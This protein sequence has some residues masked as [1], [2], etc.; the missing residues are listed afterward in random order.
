MLL[1]IASIK[2]EKRNS[3]NDLFLFSFYSC[4]SLCRQVVSGLDEMEAV[5]DLDEGTYP[6]KV[7]GDSD[8]NSAIVSTSSISHGEY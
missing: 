8:V 6:I 1:F 3:I 2:N 5:F 7:T 4:S